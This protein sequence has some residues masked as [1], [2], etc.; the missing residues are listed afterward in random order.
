MQ[1]RILI[2]FA[3]SCLTLA[4]CAAPLPSPESSKLLDRIPIPEPAEVARA[5]EPEPGCKMYACI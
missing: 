5:P 2:A 1:C 3:V 4:V